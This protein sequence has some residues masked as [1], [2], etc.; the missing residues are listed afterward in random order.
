M[1]ERAAEVHESARA[2]HER[3]RAERLR[4]AIDSGR[5]ALAS[6]EIVDLA[7]GRTVMRELLVRLIDAHGDPV[8][9]AEFLGLAERHR[10]VCEIDLWVLGRAAEVATAE[11]PVALNV[12]AQTMTDPAYAAR[13][14]RL[15]TSREVDPALFTFEITET[16]LIENFPQAQRFARRLGALGCTVALD[17]FGTGYGALTY[18]KQLPAHYLKIDRE[19]V[20]DVVSDRRSQA[21]VRGI[22]AL[23]RSFGQQTIAE[24]VEHEAVLDTLRDL[25]VDL[26]QGY[27]IGRPTA[28]A[29]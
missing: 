7:D 2:A 15:V 5:L 29:S 14:V 23:A 12:S 17:D 22:V 4:A 18:L 19:F 20:A 26:A 25:G 10:F 11:T 3:S 13:V 27:L 1:V 24:G 9:A 6:Q 16:A 8:A 21:V 28:V